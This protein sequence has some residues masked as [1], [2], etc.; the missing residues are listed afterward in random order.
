MKELPGTQKFDIS[1]VSKNPFDNPRV[2]RRLVLEHVRVDSNIKFEGKGFICALINSRCHVGCAHCMFASNM[3]EKKNETNTMTS[4]RISNLMRLVSDSNT[5]YLLVSGGGE[6]FLEPDL[7]CQIILKSSA[8]LTWMV[9]SGFWAKRESRAIQL[10]KRMYQAYLRGNITQV[11]RRV[12]IRVSFDYHHVE[13]LATDSKDPLRYIVNIINAFE[14][15]FSDQNGFFFQLHCI[16]GEEELVEDLCRRISAVELSNASL[17]HTNVK[18]TESAKTLRMPSGYEFEVTFAKLLLSDVASDL[19]DTELLDKRI[20]LWEKDAFVN[21][22]GF[23][24]CQF[25]D[26]GTI[27]N[28][29]LVIYDGRVAGGW[30]SEMPDV[31]INVD[32]DNYDS[33]MHK[34]LSDPATLA[35]IERGLAYRF[36]IIDEVCTKACTRAKAV[37]IRD[38]TSLILLEEDTVKLYYSIRAIQDFFIDG[39]LKNKEI[40]NYPTEL[41]NL[42]RMSKDE[43]KALYLSSNYDILKQFE[44]TEPG[45]SHFM[46]EIRIHAQT[47][48]IKKLFIAIENEDVIPHYRLDKWRLLFKRIENDWYDI[49]QL[50]SKELDSLQEVVREIDSKLLHGRRV[51][52]GLSM[53]DNYS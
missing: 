35:T 7:M 50:S 53:F 24:A 32:L 52:D 48:C 45:F 46:Q 19:R 16:E 12:C 42:I 29:M 6:G 22:K 30:Q 11:D 51:Y 41:R 26:D 40:D 23:T 17:L 38:Y 28:D 44:D 13:K 47:G 33:I 49:K 43:L 18:T 25:N 14:S 34:T 27:G 1:K 39:R 3:A 36:A 21:E 31:P 15:L 5:G 10:L 4:E 37:N 2:I 20:K 8:N 9:T